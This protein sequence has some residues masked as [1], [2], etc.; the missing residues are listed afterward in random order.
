M[1]PPLYQT[2]PFKQTLAMIGLVVL[3]MFIVVA[4]LL[5]RETAIAGEQSKRLIEDQATFQNNLIQEQI[6][7]TYSEL[8]YENEQVRQHLQDKVKEQVD[9]AHA[10]ASDL[11]RQ[12]QATTPPEQIKSIIVETLRDIRFFSGRGYLFIDTLEGNCVL[13]PIAPEIEGKSL[14]FQEDDTGHKIMQGLIE[15]SDNIEGQGFSTY[16]WYAP[17]YPSTMKSKISFVRRFEPF[18]WLIGAGDY[19]YRVEQDRQNDVLNRIQD[20]PLND[21]LFFQILGPEGNAIL[22]KGKDVKAV[23]G[24]NLN[25]LI[26]ATSLSKGHSETLPLAETASAEH[27]QAQLQVAKFEPWGWT[28]VAGYYPG[29]LKQT[30]N[31]QLSGL[32]QIQ[33]ERLAALLAGLVI[34]TLVALLLALMLARWLKLVFNQ[35]KQEDEKQKEM[36]MNNQKQLELASRVFDSTSEGIVITDAQSRI[37]TCN[38]AFTRITGYSEEELQGKNPS[39]ISSGLTEPQTYEEMWNDIHTKGEWQG[40]VINKHK[41]GH[42]FPE[43]L[44]IN[45][46]R[47]EQG[48][49]VN[50]IGSIIDISARKQVEEKLQYLA[51][52]DPLTD[53]PNR[54]LLNERIQ[55]LIH[56]PA[57]DGGKSAFAV[58]FLDLD[59]FKFI[60]D[61]LGHAAGD[62]VL[63]QVAE[64][65][66]NNVSNQDLVC[67][68]GGDEFVILLKKA[69]SDEQIYRL[70]QHLIAAIGRPMTV[71]AKTLVITP[72]IGVASF[73]KDGENAETLMKNADAALYLAKENGRNNMQFFTSHLN[74]K[75]ADRLS[76][77]NDLRQALVESQLELY[78]Q[79]QVDL[80]TMT[81]IG[82]EALIRWHHPSRG[83]VPPDR[84]IPLAEE[85][86]LIIEIGNWVL[87]TACAQLAEWRKTL[88]RP[89]NLA[90]NLSARQ[91]GGPLMEQVSEL[92]K[93]YDIPGEALTLE[94]TESLLMRHPEQAIR[95]LNRLRQL[96]VKV[97][98][99][100]FGTGYSSLSYLKRFPLDKLKI[101]RAFIKGL[102]DDSD[103]M[104]ITSSVLSVAQHLNLTTVAEGIETIEQADFLTQSYCNEG[105]GYLFARPLAAADMGLRIKHNRWQRP[106]L[107][108]QPANSTI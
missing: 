76:L 94:I 67:R 80:K 38:A 11:Y 79:P 101:D 3:S 26:P 9:M 74:Q 1:Q 64:R 45:L 23:S 7:A 58:L 44:S 83:M 71:M 68:N 70:C 16:R 4:Y 65:L 69:R 98:L 50:F 54:R 104:A 14:I 106:L 85:T 88:D 8:Q 6:Q 21:Q 89:F 55:Q 100:D 29:D 99:D 5:W 97:A 108:S 87:Q 32:Q 31:Q 19:L 93:K 53:L 48:E 105:Q 52:Y 57:E 30:L 91:F 20:R 60:N 17:D 43:W 37:I 102:P 18:G 82:C 78:Y 92:L 2:V 59:H 10:I 63:Q 72:S 84:F 107:L 103:D 22:S 62:K 51:H 66:S 42:L 15:A 28:L 35:Y 12:L 34:A 13:L 33:K 56:H 41:D 40:E 86:G 61:S 24:Q 36:L 25:S 96:G 47:N 95:E 39:H 73:P 27:S 46:Y 49:V 75:A 90:V 81:L 77:E